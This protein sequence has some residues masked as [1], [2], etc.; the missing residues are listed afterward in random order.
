MFCVLAAD[1][2]M[3]A[4]L[5]NDYVT[6]ARRSRQT[7]CNNCTVSFGLSMS[8]LDTVEL[9]LITTHNRGLHPSFWKK[10]LLHGISDY[11]NVNMLEGQGIVSKVLFHDSYI[12]G[13]QGNSSTDQ[14]GD[15]TIRRQGRTIRWTIGMIRQHDRTIRWQ[16]YQ[17]GYK[18]IRQQTTLPL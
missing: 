4:C 16:F 9:I 6:L 12:K 15:K 13:I 3:R 11:S 2:A 1:Y 14:F 17:F 5:L 10:N 7:L 8:S 18:L